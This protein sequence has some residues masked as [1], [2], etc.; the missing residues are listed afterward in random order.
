MKTK[1]IIA[2]T[3]LLLVFPG[4]LLMT[5]LFLRTSNRHNMNRPKL[6]GV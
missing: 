1:R 3:E 4:V 2:A 5:A 6:P